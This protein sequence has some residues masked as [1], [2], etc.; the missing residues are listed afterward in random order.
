MSVRT[1]TIAINSQRRTTTGSKTTSVT[2][3]GSFTTDA[4][5]DAE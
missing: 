3:H 4:G 5:Q 2:G 1:V